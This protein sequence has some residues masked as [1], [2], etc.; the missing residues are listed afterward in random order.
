MRYQ[1]TEDVLPTRLLDEIRKHISGAVLYIPRGDG[2]R[3]GWGELTRTREVLSERNAEMRGLYSQGHSIET[4]M[5]KYHLSYDSV[6]KIVRGAR[7][8]AVNAS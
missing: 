5:D 6:K 1:N 7:R 2:G 3:L 8:N 4:L